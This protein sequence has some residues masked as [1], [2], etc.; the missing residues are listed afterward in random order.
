MAG[1]SLQRF[2]QPLP[3]LLQRGE[4]CHLDPTVASLTAPLGK[5]D[6][7]CIAVPVTLVAGEFGPGELV[8]VEQSLAVVEPELRKAGAVV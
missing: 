3:P 2:E 7:D 1:D 6:P 5:K 8:L 4:Y